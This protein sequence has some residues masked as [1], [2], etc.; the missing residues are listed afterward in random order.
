[1]PLF[2]NLPSDLSSRVTSALSA[3]ILF[4]IHDRFEHIWNLPKRFDFF[5]KL[6]SVEPG[7]TGLQDEHPVVASVC[8]SC[9]FGRNDVIIRSCKLQP[10]EVN[11]S[12][13]YKSSKG[14]VMLGI[15]RIKSTI[16]GATLRASSEQKTVARVKQFHFTKLKYHSAEQRK[17][18]DLAA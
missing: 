16:V 9:R 14:S 8:E 18:S 10:R 15:T 7:W 6:S 12:D 5:S 17:L 2:F 13:I 4:W 1:M 11:W 3:L